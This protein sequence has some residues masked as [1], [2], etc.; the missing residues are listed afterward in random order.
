MLPI[1]ITPPY[2]KNNFD[3]E[4]RAI[5]QL[6]V[7]GLELIHVRKLDVD[8]KT[9]FAYIKSLLDVCEPSSITIHHRDDLAAKYS[10][11]GVHLSYA[12]SI[13]FSPIEGYRYSVSCH[14]IEELVEVHRMGFAQYQFISP[15]FDSISKQ[16]YSPSIDFEQLRSYLSQARSTKTVAL[17]GIDKCNTPQVK[18]LGFDGIAL[19][20][21]VWNSDSGVENYQNITKL[22]QER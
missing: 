2:L 14:T 5:E 12:R 22:W 19:L 3:S 7:K 18:D 20:G 4:I 10:L 8:E 21:A 6:F 1:V 15:I 16:G 13:E 11:G 17:G 9:Y